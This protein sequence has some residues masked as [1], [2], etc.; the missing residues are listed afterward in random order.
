[1][2]IK[3]FQVKPYVQSART[4]PYCT[5]T[6]RFFLINCRSEFLPDIWASVQQHHH[7][8]QHWYMALIN[9]TAVAVTMI[10]SGGNRISCGFLHDSVKYVKWVPNLLPAGKAAGAWRWPPTFSTAKV[11][12]GYS[13]VSTA[14]LCMQWKV[15]RWTLPVRGWIVNEI[16]RLS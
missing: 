16:F 8:L 10:T 2:N 1:M 11:E 7:P 13:Y 14:P 9:S 5:D 12:K 3:K 6:K 4:M 15:T